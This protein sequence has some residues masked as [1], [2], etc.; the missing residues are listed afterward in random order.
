MNTEMNNEKSGT[1]MGGGH[2]GEG[3]GGGGDELFDVQL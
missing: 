3:D 1:G 2:F